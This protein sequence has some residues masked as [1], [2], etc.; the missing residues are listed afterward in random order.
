MLKRAKKVKKV[1][2]AGFAKDGFYKDYDVKW[3]RETPE[4]PD[5]KLVAEFDKKYG[6]KGK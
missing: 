2:E 5:Y 4:H 3:L 6:K 1:T